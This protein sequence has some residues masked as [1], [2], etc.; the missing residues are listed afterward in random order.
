MNASQ[1]LF[2]LIILEE[3]ILLMIFTYIILIHPNFNYLYVS[4][5]LA[6]DYHI[7]GHIIQSILVRSY[8]PGLVLGVISG[9]LSIYWIVNIPVLNWILTFI[10]SL[11]F[12]ILIV[13]NLIC[14]YQIG[15]KF[16]FKK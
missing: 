13:I 4:L 9:I 5:I 15:L 14:C 2:S 10:L 7:I 12:I 6:Y 3:L 8:T 11:V 16:R 1:S